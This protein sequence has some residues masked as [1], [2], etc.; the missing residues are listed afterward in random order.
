VAGSFLSLSYWDFYFTILVAVAATHQY[1]RQSLGDTAP[2]GWQREAARLA[3]R[4]SFR[5]GTA[6]GAKARVGPTA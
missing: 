2:A 3:Q 1:V 6:I 4:P 5:G